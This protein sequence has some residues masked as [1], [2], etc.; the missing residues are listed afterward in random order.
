MVINVYSISILF[1]V[2]FLVIVIELVRKNRLQERYS[3]LWILMSLILI[4]LSSTPSIINT[5]ARWLDIKNPPSLLFLFGMVY[6]IIYSLNTTTVVSK[7]S[8]KITRL[9]QEIA[10]LS[11]K[12][13]DE[14]KK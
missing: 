8:E 4:I 14:D 7:Q 6:L 1:S 10:L 12:I 13:D 5:F 3:I 9:T 11:K 2:L